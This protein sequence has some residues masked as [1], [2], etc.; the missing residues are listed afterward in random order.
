[1]PHGGNDE[2]DRMLEVWK[3]TGGATPS[4]EERRS[5]TLHQLAFCALMVGGGLAYFRV[6]GD[7]RWQWD[8]DGLSLA[9]VGRDHPRPARPADG[10]SVRRTRLLNLLCFN[11]SGFAIER[12]RPKAAVCV[13]VRGLRHTSGSPCTSR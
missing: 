3:V 1:M 6:V 7:L 10:Y 8:A 13:S 9:V 12:S 5:L 4:S 2:F 11:G